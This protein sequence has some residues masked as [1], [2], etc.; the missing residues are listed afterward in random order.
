M[1]A[2]IIGVFE[3][4]LSQFSIHPSSGMIRFQTETIRI[5]INCVHIAV[6][7]FG[8]FLILMYFLSFQRCQFLAYYPNIPFIMT[9]QLRVR[10]VVVNECE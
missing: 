1:F 5:R 3:F 8:V 2:L 10:N 4:K 7:W 9:S 6:L